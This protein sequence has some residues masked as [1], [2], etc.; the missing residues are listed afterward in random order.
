MLLLLSGGFY[1]QKTPKKT[2]EGSTHELIMWEPVNDLTGLVEDVKSWALNIDVGS[3]WG[4]SSSDTI[5]T[6]ERKAHE[7]SKFLRS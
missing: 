6:S 4:N 1:P 7:L 3:K 5:L 2:S